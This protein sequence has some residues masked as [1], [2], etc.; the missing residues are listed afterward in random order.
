MEIISVEKQSSEPRIVVQTRSEVDIVNDG[1]RWRKYGQKLVKGNPHPRYICQFS[2]LVL[3][4]VWQGTLSKELLLLKSLRCLDLHIHTHR[5][6]H[7]LSC[8]SN[9]RVP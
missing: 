8:M 2:Y 5:Q 9:Y 4:Y 7:A 1:Y 6:T 3:H